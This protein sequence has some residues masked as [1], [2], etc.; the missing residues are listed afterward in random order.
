MQRVVAIQ[1]YVGAAAASRGGHARLKSSSLVAT[2]RQARGSALRLMSHHCSGSSAGDEHGSRS[3]DGG[4]ARTP[5]AAAGKENPFASALASSLRR[6]IFTDNYILN[7]VPSAK[8]EELLSRWRH[9]DGV[10][11]EQ[12][13]LQP[14]VPGTADDSDVA[15]R[16]ADGASDVAGAYGHT[17]RDSRPIDPNESEESKRRRLIYQS[18]YRGMVEMDLI[19][20]HFARCRLATLDA[21]MLDEYDTLLKQLDSDLFR[22]LVAGAA[23]PEAIEG[24]SCYAELQRFVKEEREELLAPS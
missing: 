16:I 13:P 21:A 6:E 5:S 18:R 12:A 9:G 23:A 7:A 17:F 2:T 10:T 4:A 20:G 1:R 24:L 19:F 22:W 15:P 3:A 14:A 11:P 8:E